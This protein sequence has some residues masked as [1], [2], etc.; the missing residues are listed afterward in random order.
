[1]VQGSLDAAGA[2]LTVAQGRVTEL[3]GDRKLRLEV[4]L[5]VTRL[6][7]ARRRGD[8]GTVL[9]TVEPLL[10]PAQSEAVGRVGLT[11]EARA[12]ALMDLGI[13]E[14]WAFRRDAAD[15]H[16]KEALELARRIGLAHVEVGCLSHRAVLDAWDSFEVVR[17]RC[18][19]TLAAAQAHGLSTHPIVCVALTMMGLMDVAQGRFETGLL[20]CSSARAACC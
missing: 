17:Q 14:L 13:V 6:S 10:R 3:T 1:L 2:Y 15:R 4:V 12:A 16:L 8:F 9:Q 20:C 19:Q 11:N 5:A 18:E 7:L